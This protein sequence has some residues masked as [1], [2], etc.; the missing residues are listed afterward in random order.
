[1]NCIKKSGVLHCDRINRDG[2]IW[3]PMLEIISTKN[4]KNVSHLSNRDFAR[5][6][7]VV[8]TRADGLVRICRNDDV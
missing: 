5:I 2:M 6:E 8:D 3:A 7:R 4:Y 1:M